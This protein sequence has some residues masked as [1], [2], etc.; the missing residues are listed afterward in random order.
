[1]QVSDHLQDEL[2]LLMALHHLTYRHL[3][4]LRRY[5][6]PLPSHN[7][8]LS[9]ILDPL[10]QFVQLLLLDCIHLD[11]VAVFTNFLGLMLVIQLH[12]FRIVANRPI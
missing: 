8:L 10:S 3:S 1:M 12:D 4:L 6:L 5:F 7:Q 2:I 11:L 9:I